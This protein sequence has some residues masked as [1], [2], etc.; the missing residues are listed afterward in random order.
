[1]VLA[2]G[3]AQLYNNW[4]W[5]F[6]VFIQLNISKKDIANTLFSKT[7]IRTNEK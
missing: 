5:P 1:M 3:I 6:E 2:P 7:K 4:K